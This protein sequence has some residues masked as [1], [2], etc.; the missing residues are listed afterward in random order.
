M[1][2]VLV[3]FQLSDKTMFKFFVQSFL[4]LVAC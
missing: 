4:V 1:H 3:L 2:N